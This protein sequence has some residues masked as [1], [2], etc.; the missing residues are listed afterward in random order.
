MRYGHIYDDFCR[1]SRCATYQA[2]SKLKSILN[3]SLSIKK[4]IAM[5]ETVKCEENC[6]CTAYELREWLKINEFKFP[7]P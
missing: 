7:F 5:I 6:E 2:L 1:E 3:P 4:D